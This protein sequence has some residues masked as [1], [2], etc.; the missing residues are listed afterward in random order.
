M[1]LKEPKNHLILTLFVVTGLVHM[2]NNT[3]TSCYRHSFCIHC[4][5]TLNCDV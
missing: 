3:F 1:S 5:E 4:Q 2:E